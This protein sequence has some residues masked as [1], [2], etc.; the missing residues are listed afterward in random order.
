[1]AVGRLDMNTEG[2][3]LL[4]TDGAL[5]RSLELPNTIRLRRAS[6]SFSLCTINLS[7][8]ISASRACTTRRSASA[9]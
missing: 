5:K 8:R 7:I 3:L 4:T 6:C 1:M 9:A 2:L